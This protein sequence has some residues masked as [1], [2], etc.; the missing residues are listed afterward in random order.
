ME[1]KKFAYK[2]YF[3][4][5][6]DTGLISFNDKIVISVENGILGGGRDDGEFV[7]FMRLA[8][9]EWFDGSFV[10]FVEDE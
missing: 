1:E 10:S 5:K 4:A 9:K 7:E 3:P 8:L 6:M 2:I